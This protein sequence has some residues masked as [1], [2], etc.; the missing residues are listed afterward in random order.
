[1]NLIRT[2][3]IVG[4]LILSALLFFTF[5]LNHVDINEVGVAYDPTNGTIARQGPG[6]H[7]TGPLVRATTIS[8][9]PFRVEINPQQ[10]ASQRVLNVKLVRFVPEHLDEFIATEGFHYTYTA[11]TFAPYVFSGKT[12]PFVEILQ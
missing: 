2:L 4:S 12:Y 3:I 8:L 9:L 5:C 6:W 1:M 11:W 10:G 7:V